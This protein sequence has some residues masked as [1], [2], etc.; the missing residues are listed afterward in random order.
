MAVISFE[1]LNQLIPSFNRIFLFDWIVYKFATQRVE[2]VS[3][4]VLITYTGQFW[5]NS[6]W[7][8]HGEEVLNYRC[9]L[10]IIPVKVSL[11]VPHG[12]E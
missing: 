10:S 8:Q 5:I 7:F 12:R 4:M 2:K 1:F 11:H 6:D 3:C 9:D